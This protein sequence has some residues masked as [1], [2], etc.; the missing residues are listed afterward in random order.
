MAKPA[1]ATP[2]PQEIKDPTDVACHE[3]GEVVQPVGGRHQ[4]ENDRAN[5]PDETQQRTEECLESPDFRRD[6]APATSVTVT[7]YPGEDL[8]RMLGGSGPPPP[9]YRLFALL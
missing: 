3:D 1:P 7:S 4:N 2:R 6:Y 8:R 9:R 5:D